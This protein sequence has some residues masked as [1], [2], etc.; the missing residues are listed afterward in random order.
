MLTTAEITA[1]RATSDTALPDVAT[2][3]R[4]TTVSDGGGGTTTSWADVATVA[5]RI[6]P[7]G[8]ASRGGETG[9]TGGRIV[10]ESTHVISLPAEADVTAADRL[11]IDGQAYDVTLVHRRGAWELSRRVECKEAVV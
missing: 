8:G 9:V 10:D 4:A 6:A 2:V 3:Q 5:C 1:M 11:F 7:T